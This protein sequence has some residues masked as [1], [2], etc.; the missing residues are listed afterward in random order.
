MLGQSSKK[1]ICVAERLSY[2]IIIKHNINPIIA[3]PEQYS[4]VYEAR[5]RFSN[6]AKMVG[7]FHVN[8]LC[9]KNVPYVKRTKRDGTHRI[10]S[11][12]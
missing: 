11:G 8:Q 6:E 7:Q 2:E 4:K 9:S 5:I 3:P 1:N 10:Q 12:E